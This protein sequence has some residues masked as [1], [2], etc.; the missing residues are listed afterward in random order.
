MNRVDP[1]AWRADVLA[2]IVVHPAH[3]PD[4]LLP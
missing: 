4:E 1:Q 3:W 2:R